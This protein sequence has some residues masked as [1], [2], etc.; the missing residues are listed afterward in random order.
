MAVDISKNGGQQPKILI[1]DQNL[2]PTLPNP[3]TF[4]LCMHVSTGIDQMITSYMFD[5]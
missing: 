2:S 3:S 1:A 4:A 5:I